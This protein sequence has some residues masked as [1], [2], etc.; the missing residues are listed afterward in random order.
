MKLEK[1]RNWRELGKSNLRL[2]KNPPGEFW[3][4]FSSVD[5][6]LMYVWRLDVVSSCRS[7]NLDVGWYG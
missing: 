3:L 4:F 7:W 2:R 5:R 1:W 6:L